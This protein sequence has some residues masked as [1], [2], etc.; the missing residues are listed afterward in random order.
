MKKR[1]LIS[2]IALLIWYF[3][4]MIGVKIGDKY[5][6]E[7]AFKDEWVFMLIPCATFLLMLLTGKLGK[8][9]HLIWLVMW[10]VTQFLSHEWYTMFGKGFMGNVDDKIAYFKNCIQLVSIDGR[11]VPDIYHLVLHILIIIAFISTAKF[12]KSAKSD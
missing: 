1:V 9:L 7:G 11:Y 5:L 2:N 6:V 8:I 3:F 12:C 10:F 4:A